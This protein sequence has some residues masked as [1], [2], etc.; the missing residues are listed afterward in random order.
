VVPC[1]FHQRHAS[2]HAVVA[3]AAG[4]RL[5][6]PALRV[7]FNRFDPSGSGSLQLTEF[8]ALTLFMRSATA[9]FNAFDANRV[10][11][12]TLNFNQFIYSW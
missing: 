3:A 12:I 7:L 1:T 6:P 2:C 10:G 4:Y 9:T 5:D 8:L 11:N